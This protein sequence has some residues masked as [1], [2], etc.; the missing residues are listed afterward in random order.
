MLLTLVL[1]PF[2][3][4][5]NVLWAVLVCYWFRNFAGHLVEIGQISGVESNYR[6]ICNYLGRYK[7]TP[8]PSDFS[9]VRYSYVNGEHETL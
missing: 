4:I 5:T 9:T 6:D 7:D 1:S 8:V 3:I 2:T